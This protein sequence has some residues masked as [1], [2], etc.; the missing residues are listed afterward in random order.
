MTPVHHLPLVLHQ[1]CDVHEHLVQ[2]L[3]RRLQFHKHLVPRERINVT[4]Y[5]IVPKKTGL[6][7][8]D[9]SLGNWLFHKIVSKIGLLGLVRGEW[10]LTGLFQGQ[11]VAKHISLSFAKEETSTSAQF[12][13]SC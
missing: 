9:V 10:S 6:S 8:E 3:D 11:I 13:N 4:N 5:V 12:V 1:H 2:L 7:F